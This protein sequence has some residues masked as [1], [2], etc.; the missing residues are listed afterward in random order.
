MPDPYE[1]WR[2]SPREMRETEVGRS[3]EVKNRGI[4]EG[5]VYP[6]DVAL[7]SQSLQIEEQTHQTAGTAKAMTHS[8]ACMVHPKLPTAQEKMAVRVRLW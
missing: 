6:L 5:N 4:R 1:P 8:V 3:V 7:R 2:D